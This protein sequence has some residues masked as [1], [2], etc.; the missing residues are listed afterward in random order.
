[1]S[2]DTWLPVTTE[3]SPESRNGHTAIWDGHQMIIWGGVGNGGV[4]LNTGGRYNP[5][6]DTWLPVTTEGSPES[7][8]GHTAIWDDHQMIIWGGADNEGVS[9]TGSKFSE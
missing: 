9:N 5:S 3:G 8:N 1:P 7:R 2:T 6:T 4:G